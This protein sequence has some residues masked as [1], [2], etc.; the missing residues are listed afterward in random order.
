MDT[1]RKEETTWRRTIGQRLGDSR[2]TVWEHE[3]ARAGLWEME[4]ICGSMRGYARNDL[5]LKFTLEKS[6]CF[7]TLYL[8]TT[9]EIYK[10]QSTLAF[11]M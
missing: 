5:N 2:K 3:K 11:D 1:E 10:K 8:S 6:L 9:A 7:K 4:T